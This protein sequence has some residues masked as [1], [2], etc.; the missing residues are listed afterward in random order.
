M[1]GLGQKT[2]G[3]Q[4]TDCQC[5]C[6]AAMTYAGNHGLRIGG[7]TGLAGAAADVFFS[8]VGQGVNEAFEKKIMVDIFICETCGDLRFKYCGGL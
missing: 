1:F 3:Q 8:N 2:S 4:Y 6:G 5:G 7:I